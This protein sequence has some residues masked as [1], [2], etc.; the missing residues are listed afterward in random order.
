MQE[1]LERKIKEILVGENYV[2][3]KYIKKAEEFARRS[4][5]SFVGYLINERLITNDLL[6]QAIAEYYKIPYADLNSKLPSK[7]QILKVPEEVAV[8]H[9]IVL[10]SESPQ[11]LVFATDQP[12]PGLLNFLKSQLNVPNIS[13]SY[14]LSEDIDQILSSA[15]RKTL[16]TR[17]SVI[18]EQETRVA[19]EIIDEIFSDAISFRS[20]DIHLE[21]QGEEVVVRFRVDG[22]LHEAGRIAK[23]YYENIVNHIKV[24]SHLRTDE[25]F[26]AQDGALKFEKEG[27]AVDM[28]VSLIPTLEGE[29]IVIRILAR[30][31]RGFTLSDL[32]LSAKNL[33]I[34][35]EMSQ[36]PFGMI[37][38]TG[39]TGSGKT[40]TLYAVLNSLNRPEVNITT[41]EDPVEYR[42]IGVNQIQVNTRTNLTFSK[43]LRSIVRQDPDI[44]LVG[45]IR[46]LETAEIAVNAA[47]TGHLLLSTFHANDAATGIPRLLDM[48]IEPFLLASTL[49]AIVGQRLVRKICEQCR[50]SYSISR[51][52]LSQKYSVAER[53]FPDETA[54]LYKG[55]G[56]Q[57]CNSTG[58]KGRTAVFEIIKMTA[59]VHNLILKN[60][61]AREIWQLARSQGASS[62]FEDGVEKAKSGTTTLE[63]VLRVTMPG[64]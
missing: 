50:V 16:E 23:K 52:E 43:G 15:Y 19:P 34:L 47:L 7:E 6:G 12:S 51:T 62:M 8:K 44:I 42:I 22:V 33:E 1:A 56:C 21:P 11:G 49:Q 9:R 40:T 64:D 55:K 53:Y 28:R 45:E 18:T 48:K 38:I 27:K 4:K 37:L 58:Y 13:L 63:E 35:K 2:S 57:A 3:E 54:T 10:F 14:S 61:S 41:I 5:T 17:F 32:G 39:P 30:Y 26:A 20:S 46:D 36:K 25:H 59:E 29:K 60:P 24:R 31:I